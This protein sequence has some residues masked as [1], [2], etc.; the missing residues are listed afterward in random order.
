[1]Y[2]RGG[3][4]TMVSMQ[5]LRDVVKDA[6]ARKVAVGHFNVSDSEQL[7]GIF[8]AAR[9]LNL[10]VIIGLSEGERDFVGVRQAVALVRSLREEFDYPVFV[11]ADHTYSLDRLREAI[12]AG[13]DAVIFDGTKLSFD[14]NIAMT[15][16]AVAYAKAKNPDILVEG[17]LGFIGSSS[18]I[19]DGIPAGAEITDEHLTKPEEI[20]R[21]VRETGVD[22]VAPAVGN[23]HGM[24]R[25]GKNPRLNTAR[26]AELRR[27]A[28]VPLVLHGGSGISDQDFRDAIAAGI[29][30]VHINTEIRLAYRRG[31]EKSLAENPNEIAPYRFMKGGVDAVVEVVDARLRLFSNL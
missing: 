29:S 28:G 5:M 12:D 16:E 2:A 11:N 27:A 30:T 15:K 23:I 26:I 9:A 4:G 31:I 25:G 21:F 8:S 1:M 6:E 3:G 24:L 17:E 22:F 13:F 18:K 14:E 20:E 7:R 19:L 10:P